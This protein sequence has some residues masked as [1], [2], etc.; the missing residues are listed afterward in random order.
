MKN[1]D[2]NILTEKAADVRDAIPEMTLHGSGQFLVGHN[3]P[4]AKS[5]LLE[6]LFK[7]RELAGDIHRALKAEPRI[8]RGKKGEEDDDDN[9]GNLP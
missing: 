7:A 4:I 2:L 1:D 3:V 8:T 6:R 5:E 9:G